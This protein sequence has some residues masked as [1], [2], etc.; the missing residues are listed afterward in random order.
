M[1]ASEGEF[2]AR[3]VVIEFFCEGPGEDVFS[4]QIETGLVDGELEY[5]WKRKPLKKEMTV[6]LLYRKSEEEV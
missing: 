6:K 4:F 5:L 2:R 1:S 3:A